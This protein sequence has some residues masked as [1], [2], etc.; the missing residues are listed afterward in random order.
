VALCVSCVDGYGGHGRGHVRKRLRVD[1]W[2]TWVPGWPE[3]SYVISILDLHTILTSSSRDH[4]ITASPI[5]A[6]GARSVSNKLL[7]HQDI[8]SKS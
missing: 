8:V 1:R 5:V 6:P 7:S 3:R 2:A 4:V